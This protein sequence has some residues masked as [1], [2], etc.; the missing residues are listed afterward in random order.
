MLLASLGHPVNVID[1]STTKVTPLAEAITFNHL[2]IAVSLTKLGADISYQDIRGENAL[3]H[4]ARLGSTRMI[5]FIL[6]SVDIFV[7]EIQS[8][9]ST[10]K[11]CIIPLKRAETHYDDQR[12]C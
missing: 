6:N 12:E 8:L 3:H 4:C 9:A 5:S 2:D 1:S 10:G 11:F 7:D